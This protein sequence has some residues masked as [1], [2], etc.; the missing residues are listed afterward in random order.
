M[1]LAKHWKRNLVISAIIFFALF[2]FFSNI[3]PA[4]MGFVIFPFFLFFYIPLAI[5][6]ILLSQGILGGIFVGLTKYGFTKVGIGILLAL[7]LILIL[8]PK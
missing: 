6:L 7:I 5:G 1:Y 4:G 3:G 8:M 2:S